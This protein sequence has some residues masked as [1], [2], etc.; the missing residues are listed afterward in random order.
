[1][2]AITGASACGKSSAPTPVSADRT[3][4]LSGS[5]AETA[6][7]AHLLTGVRVQITD[8]P[9][10]GLVATSDSSGSFRFAVLRPGAIG[11]VATKD[12]YLPWRVLNLSVETYP[13]IQIVLYP[14]PPTDASGTLA[15]VRC[16]DGAWSWETS[17]GNL[18]AGNGGTAYT[19]CPGPL[20]IGGRQ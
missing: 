11:I 3:W 17:F 18:C 9:D 2:I 8:G 5:T 14:V 19:V 20:C 1:V 13:Q 4:T 16:N 15:T 7:N 12:G 10:A 6:P